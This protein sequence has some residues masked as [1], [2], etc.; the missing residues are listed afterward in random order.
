MPAASFEA[1]PVVI[2]LLVAVGFQ[3]VAVVAIRRRDIG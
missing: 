2:L 3:T 1:L